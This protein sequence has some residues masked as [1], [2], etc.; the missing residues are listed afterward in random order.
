MDVWCII[1]RMGLMFPYDILVTGHKLWNF[2][3]I[4]LDCCLLVDLL[5]M[6]VWGCVCKGCVDGCVYNIP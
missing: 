2:G 6:Y 4:K 5:I 1:S 3:Y